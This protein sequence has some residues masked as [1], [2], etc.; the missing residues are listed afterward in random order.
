MQRMETAVDPHRVLRA[1]VLGEILFEGLQL[2]PQDEVA[3]LQRADDR[4][5]HLA[6]EVFPL[7][8]RLDKA[9]L[10]S[11]RS[12]TLP[13]QGIAHRGGDPRRMESELT[14]E[15]VLIADFRGELVRRQTDALENPRTL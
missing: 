3:L 14:A 15:V 8:V 2:R 13:A 10:V 11:H 1:D 4:R 9:N 7:H 5:L 6:P 12:A